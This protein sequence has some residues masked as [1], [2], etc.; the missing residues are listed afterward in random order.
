MIKIKNIE[1]VYEVLWVEPIINLLT[2]EDNDL[3]N[4]F[5]D[6]INCLWLY[7]RL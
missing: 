2:I 3:E 6:V 5:V 4:D 1:L 7:N